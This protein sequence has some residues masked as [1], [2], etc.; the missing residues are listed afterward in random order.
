MAIKQEKTLSRCNCNLSKFYKLINSTICMTEFSKSDL[1]FRDK[2]T[3]SARNQ[4]SGCGSNRSRVATPSRDGAPWSSHCE[5][6]PAGGSP[7]VETELPPSTHH[8]GFAINSSRC[9]TFVLAPPSR[10]TCGFP[11]KKKERE[12][13]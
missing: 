8:Y 12:E 7:R 1:K 2:H 5:R 3:W 9:E 11:E 6:G 13:E 4:C 10:A